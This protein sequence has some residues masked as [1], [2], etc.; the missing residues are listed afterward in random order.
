M[1][2]AELEKSIIDIEQEYQEMIIN[3]ENKEEVKKWNEDK[4]SC[5]LRES[6]WKNDSVAI[7]N[8]SYPSEN[9]E[10]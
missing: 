7:F 3:S 1:S 9:V 2:Y 10:T 8:I 5:F 6:I 4:D